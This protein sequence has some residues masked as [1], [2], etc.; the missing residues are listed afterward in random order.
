MN[1][2]IEQSVT[3]S[4]VRKQILQQ[5]VADG[6]IEATGKESGATQYSIDAVAKGKYVQDKKCSNGKV[7]RYATGY[8]GDK[9]IYI[10]PTDEYERE[11]GEYS[12]IDYLS[13]FN[14]KDDP[15]V[16]DVILNA[17]KEAIAKS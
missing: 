7:T 10:N 13:N 4:G 17:V 11:Y 15:G 5:L 6:W 1:E 12:I 9:G 16:Y 2:N 8:I 3:S 14:I